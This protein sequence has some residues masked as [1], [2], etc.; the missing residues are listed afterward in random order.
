MCCDDRLFQ[1]KQ[2]LAL[3]GKKR[4]RQRMC[5]HTP[6]QLSYGEA[7]YFNIVYSELADLLHTRLFH[8]SCGQKGQ[9]KIFM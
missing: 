8:F 4:E 5:L 6:I 2:T 1:W 7:F 9:N 3:F